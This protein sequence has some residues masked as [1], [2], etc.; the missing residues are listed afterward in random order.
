VTA[1]E[2]DEE[3][4]EYEASVAASMDAEPE[5]L[6][7]LPELFADLED[8]GARADDVAALLEPLGLDADAR[9]LDLGCGKGAAALAVAAR[10]GCRVRGVDAMPEFMAHATRRAE[11]LGLSAHCTFEVGDIR[12]EVIEAEDYDVVMLLALGEIFGSLEGTLITLEP[13]VKPGG[14]IVIDDAFIADDADVPEES[15]EYCYDHATTL[16]V[17]DE[18]GFDVVG[19]KR[20]D[21]DLDLAWLQGMAAKVLTRAEAL[22]DKRPELKD[23]ILTFAARQVEET[24][25]LTGPV[26]GATW[27]LRKRS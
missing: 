23:A 27:V 5:L 24:K 2:L 9:V 1:S 8:L 26:V 22:A 25:T 17:F 19:E 6:A 20:F 12:E 16:G 11:A 3:R 14:L 10:F 21:S 18:L 15:Y 13:C 4:E 7:V